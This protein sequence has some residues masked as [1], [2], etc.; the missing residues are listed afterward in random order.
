MMLVVVWIFTWLA[1]L[2]ALSYATRHSSQ[3]GPIAINLLA[4]GIALVAAAFASISI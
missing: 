2:V 3:P 4:G 1:A